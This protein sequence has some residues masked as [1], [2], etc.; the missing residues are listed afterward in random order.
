MLIASTKA[1]QQGTEVKEDVLTQTRPSGQKRALASTQSCVCPLRSG[2]K[3]PP[4][5]PSH[6]H[7][8]TA[9]SGQTHHPASKA[10]QGCVVTFMGLFAPMGLVLCEKGF[11]IIFYNCRGINI[12]IL[13]IKAFSSAYKFLFFSP[14]DF[15]RNKS[16]VSP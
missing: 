2:H 13:Y 16:I 6:R 11:K 10:G 8:K 5:P 9:P 1:C 12:L 4:C 15:E 14:S 7:S 3:V